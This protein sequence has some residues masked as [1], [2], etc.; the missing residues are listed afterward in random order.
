MHYFLFHVSSSNGE[1]DR[2]HGCSSRECLVFFSCIL[3]F[4]CCGFLRNFWTEHI[5]IRLLADHQ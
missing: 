4:L 1:L 5:D 3:A 2:F